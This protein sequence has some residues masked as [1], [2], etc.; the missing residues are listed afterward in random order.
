MNHLTINFEPCEPAPANG[1]KIFYRVFGVGAYVAWPSNFSA[2][3]AEFSVS[4]PFGASYQGYVVGDCG[5]GQL[6][7]QYPWQ[8]INGEAPSES[9]SVSG[10]ASES[11]SV[12]PPVPCF[13]F[14]NDNEFNITIDYRD[15]NGNDI[16]GVTLTPTSEICAQEILAQDAGTIA[17]LGACPST[18]ELIL[19]VAPGISVGNITGISHSGISY[20]VSGATDDGI[21]TGFAGGVIN[22]SIGSAGSGTIEVFYNGIS[23]ASTAWSGAGS[24]PL[25]LPAAGGGTNIRVEVS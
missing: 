12:A 25:A 24:Y 16:N 4:G 1:Y 22:V 9:Q 18:G 8:A 20:P 11:E 15:C 2:S 10:S 7:V 23:Q 14:Q 19:E 13:I 17:N 5:N 3:P 6:G 21:W